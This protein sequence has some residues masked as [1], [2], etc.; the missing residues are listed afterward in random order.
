MTFRILPPAPKALPPDP[1]R[2]A[3]RAKLLAARNELPDREARSRVLCDRLLRWL[4]TMPL[5]RLAFYWP[6]RGEPDVTAA[7]VTWLA[8]NPERRAALPV[9]AGPL[10]E[11]APWHPRMPMKAG[12]FGIQV[13]DTAERIRPQ[14]LVIPCVGIDEQRHRLGYGAGFYD[15][16]LAGLPVRPS[17]VGIAFDCGRVRSIDPKP[18]DIQLELAITESGVL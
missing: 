3:L 4:R 7:V 16:T 9:V 12:E 13:P 5:Q 8:E 15:R 6:T 1:A 10:L 11:F 18:H 17:T 2:G 14:L